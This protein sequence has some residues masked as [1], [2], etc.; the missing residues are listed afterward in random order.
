M[1]SWPLGSRSWWA[2]SRIEAPRSMCWVTPRATSCC[3][4]GHRHNNEH[5]YI[6]GIKVMGLTIET[7]V[8]GS[9]GWYH[10]PREH[11]RGT[12]WFLKVSML[13]LCFLFLLVEDRELTYIIAHKL[14]IC[15]PL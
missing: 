13:G 10:L 11:G 1:E 15:R 4:D 5:R 14:H 2:R 3:A 8:N 12:A 6:V 7:A 9:E